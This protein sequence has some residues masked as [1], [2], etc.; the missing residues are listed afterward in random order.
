MLATIP[1]KVPGF[2]S[3]STPPIRW[4]ISEKYGGVRACWNPAKMILYP[5]LF[6][7]VVEFR[8]R[9]ALIGLRYSRNGRPLPVSNTFLRSFPN[10]F[11]DGGV[12]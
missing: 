9:L 10:V 11:L 5:D 3:T 2:F 4:W 6:N 1:Y 8:K 7:C 12:W